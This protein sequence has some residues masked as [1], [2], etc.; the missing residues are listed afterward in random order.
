VWEEAPSI[1]FYVLF[2]AAGGHNF[3]K[4]IVVAVSVVVAVGGCY[5]AYAQHRRAQSHVQKLVNDLSSLQSAEDALSTLQQ[6]YGFFS[7]V[8]FWPF[9]SLICSRYCQ[10]SHSGIKLK[11]ATALNFKALTKSLNCF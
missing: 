9:I 4:D 11:A 8:F 3:I 5:F 2:V 7:P 10:D 1:I 6:Q